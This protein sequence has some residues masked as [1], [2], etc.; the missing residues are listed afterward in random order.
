MT[1]YNIL[2]NGSISLKNR[3]WLLLVLASLLW[4]TSFPVIKAGLKYSSPI[5]LVFI[6]FLF[7]GVIGLLILLRITRGSIFPI[8]RNRTIIGLGV[9]NAL[10]FYLQFTGQAHTLAAKAALLVNLYVIFVG[11]VAYWVLGERPQLYHILV[12]VL[13]LI[14]V[15][16]TIIGS[17]GIHE[18][19]NAEG[20]QGDLL[21]LAAAFVWAFYIVYSRKIASEYPPTVIMAGV[22]F[23]TMIPL[24]LMY[25]LLDRTFTIPIKAVWIGFYL[26]IFCSILPY[27]FYVFALREIEALPSS[28]VLLLEIIFAVFW[29]FL[30]LGERFKLEEI[31]GGILVMSAIFM[32]AIFETR[33]IMKN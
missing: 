33:N 4:S 20:V 11:F 10:G 16:F 13:A 27:T 6:R 17:Y 21:I 29:S 28:I 25:I 18:T 1:L 22:M 14:G 15:S 24:L 8:L 7:A 9:I 23:W 30:F 5:E 2:P 31:L 12:L 26:A 3:E 19:F 32:L